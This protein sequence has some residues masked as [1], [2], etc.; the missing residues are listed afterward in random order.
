M[1]LCALIALRLLLALAVVPPWQHPDEPQHVLAVCLHGGLAS[2]SQAEHEV[3]I[4]RSM[5][6][7]EFWGRLSL[8][9]PPTTH[10]RFE[11]DP[12]LLGLEMRLP[13]GGGAYYRLAGLWSQ[14]LGARDVDDVLR[15]TRVLSAAAGVLTVLL[16]FLA[17]RLLLGTWSAAGVGCL[18]A[19]HPQFAL[20][21]TTASPDAVVGAM[22]ALVI[23]MG[24]RSLDSRRPYL[25]LASAL[26][27]IA[28]AA[29]SRRIGMTL[30]PLGAWLA[31][32]SLAQHGPRRAARSLLVLL[33]VLVAGL[34]A[35]TGMAPQVLQSAVGDAVLLL[36]RGTGEISYWG[37]L[38][39]LHHS[40]W[41]S[42]GWLR[43]SPPLW[44]IDILAVLTVVAVAG[45]VRAA[46]S[47]S[48][49]RA[50]LA[51]VASLGAI[52][53]QLV[54]IYVAYVRVGQG[55]PGR[56]LTPVGV[57]VMILLWVGVVTLDGGKPGRWPALV[58]VASMAVLSV[59]AWTS[60]ILPGF[61]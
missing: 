46:A 57:L 24:M 42:G 20:I 40:A 59:G 49:P 34:A 26:P 36:T 8:A 35:V 1:C 27:V 2:P 44:W 48:W 33:G 12:Q 19:L 37:V 45:A 13:G 15:A 60:V 3:E 5:A 58:L 54:A 7:H 30:I 28:F 41:L 51:V 56:Y 6:R 47:G 22:A 18:A 53:L 50:R 38:R 52:T 4:L 55:A 31:L 14:A 23:W 61:W 10:T 16:A 32:L 9:P 25:W 29:L 21:A 43:L 11:E 39:G 17:V